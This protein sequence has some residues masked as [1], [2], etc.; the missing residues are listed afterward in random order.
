MIIP[1]ISVVKFIL[2]IVR[3]S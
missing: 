2:F 3:L 1:T